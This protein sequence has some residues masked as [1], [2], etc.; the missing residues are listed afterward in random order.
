MKTKMIIAVLTF[1]LGVSVQ[2][3]ETSTVTSEE[4]T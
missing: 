4:Q 1:L 2:A 3:Q